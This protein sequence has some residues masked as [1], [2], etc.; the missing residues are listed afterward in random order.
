MRLTPAGEMAVDVRFAGAVGGVMSGPIVK[1]KPLLAEPPTL[2]TTFPVVAA[3]GTTTP[4]LVGFQ[5]TAGPAGTPLNVTVLVPCVAP[6]FAPDSIT[7]LPT[8]PEGGLM[9]VMLGGGGVT[10]KFT[11]LLATLLTVTTTLPVVAFAGTSTVILVV[12]HALAGAAGV[13]LKFT[14]LVPCVVPKL[15]P[16]IVTEDPTGP[17]VE[18]KLEIFGGGTSEKFTPLLVNPLTTTVTMAF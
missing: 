1:V 13:P 8:G 5:V 16:V 11:P 12:L 3:A 9:L 14:E 18:L 17:T 2:T 6:K 15:V 7:K 10:M 4:A